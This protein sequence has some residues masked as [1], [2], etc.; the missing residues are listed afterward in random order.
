MFFAWQCLSRTAAKLDRQA[1]TL[2]NIFGDVAAARHPVRV[3]QQ[4]CLMAL[5]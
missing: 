3:P 2:D 5:E 4:R 1:R